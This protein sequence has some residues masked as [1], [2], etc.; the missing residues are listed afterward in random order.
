MKNWLIHIAIFFPLLA[1]SQELNSELS[2]KELLIG[3]EVIIEYTIHTQTKDSIEFESFQNSIPVRLTS[4]TGSLSSSATELECLKPFESEESSNN[5][6][7]TWIGRYVVTAW[8]S[9]T[10]LI[11]GPKVVINDSMEYFPDLVLQSQLVAKKKDVDLYDI[12]ENYAELPSVYSSVVQYVKQFWWILAIVLALV[13]FLIL[14]KKRKTKEIAPAPDKLISLKE[15]TLRAIDSL[16]DAKYWE[17][18]QLKTHFVELSYI[19]RSYLTARYQISLLEKT[20]HES[21]LLL[22]Q[23]GLEKETIDVILKILSQSDMVKFAQSNPDVISI[24]RISA[25]AKQ[26]VAETS[27]LEFENVE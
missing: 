19:I 14:R 4:A 17:K 9:G 26:V 27:P 25:Q 20:T 8:D 11:P 5:N 3:Q 7:K 21:A 13:I 18:N 16:D 12:R 15:R 22:A 6:R 1:L 23:K 24:L 2:K 10:F